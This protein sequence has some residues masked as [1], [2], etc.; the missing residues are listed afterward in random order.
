M[1][2]QVITLIEINQKKT[3]N[4]WCNLYMESKKA[5]LTEIESFG[6]QKQGSGGNGEILVKE[7]KLSVIK[8]SRFW[9]SNV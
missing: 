4:A 3:N 1:D 7:Y 5:K 2:L 8:M 9:S 6:C